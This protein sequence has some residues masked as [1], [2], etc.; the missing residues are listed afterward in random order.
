[1]CVIFIQKE[2]SCT[3]P[4]VKRIGLVAPGLIVF[5][6]YLLVKTTEKIIKITQF[7]LFDQ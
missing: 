2:F 5:D 1:M 6:Q 4:T 3:V 7:L